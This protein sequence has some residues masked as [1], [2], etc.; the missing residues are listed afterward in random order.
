MTVSLFWMAAAAVVAPLLGR[1][2]RGRAPEVVVLLLVGVLIGPH[3]LGLASTQGIEMIKQLGMGL[4]FLLAGMEIELKSLVGRQGRWA[5]TT[6]TV[7]FVVAVFFAWL[8]TPDVDFTQAVALGLAISSTALGTLLPILKDRGLTDTPLGR[9]IFTHGAVGEIGPVVVMA[10]LL[11]S[12][13]PL[14]AGL[15]MGFFVLVTLAVIAVPTR[16]QRRVGLDPGQGSH[17]SPWSLRTLLRAVM[18][19]PSGLM[20]LAAILEFD[21]VL[22]A[23]AAGVVLSRIGGHHVHEIAESLEHVGFGF[24]IPMFFVASGMAI[25][26]AALAEHPWVLLGLAVVIGLARG[27]PVF[28]TEQLVDT[29]SGLSTT[30]KRLELGL[31][32]ATGLPIIVAVTEV[33]LASDLMDATTASLLVGAGALTVLAFPLAAQLVSRTPSPKHTP[34]TA[35]RRPQGSLRRTGFRR[36]LRPSGAARSPSAGAAGWASSSG[37]T[38]PSRGRPAPDSPCRGPARPSCGRRGPGSRSCPAPAAA[39]RSSPRRTPAG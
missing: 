39:G 26:V 17:L 10:L 24:F 6:W 33:A 7:G 31:Y 14:Q 9:A 3:V 25:E 30:R 38:S 15:L 23:F 11:T 36:R 13:S 22:G 35:A 8:I 5:W 12:H 2:A 29:G 1:L 37:C 16:L 32:A 4:L 21:A 18:L 20:A 28:L 19:L 27:L 34:L